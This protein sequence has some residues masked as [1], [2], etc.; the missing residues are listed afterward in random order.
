MVQRWCDA[1]GLY[2]RFDRVECDKIVKKKRKKKT[3]YLR[4]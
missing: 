1:V 2:H 4:P 3:T